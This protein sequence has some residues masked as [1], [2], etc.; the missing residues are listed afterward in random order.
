MQP[1]GH[2]KAASEQPYG[3]HGQPCSKPKESQKKRKQPCILQWGL[4]A[5]ASSF[6]NAIVMYFLVSF[7]NTVEMIALKTH[8]KELDTSVRVGSS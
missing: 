2:P 3:P 1:Q 8:Q 7:M 4:A 5:E 6:K